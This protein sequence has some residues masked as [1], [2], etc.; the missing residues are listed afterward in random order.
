MMNSHWFLRMTLIGF[1]LG[2][3]F[4]LPG[5]STPRIADPLSNDTWIS[6]GNPEPRILP[7][8]DFSAN[9]VHPRLFFRAEDIPALRE[10]AAREPYETMV[11]LM[12]EYVEQEGEGNPWYELAWRI[13]VMALLHVISGEQ[14]D[15]DRTLDMVQQL[16]RGRSD[17]HRGV[18]HRVEGRQL[19]LSEGSLSVAMAYDFCYHAWPEDAR[20]DISRDLAEQA[21]R[22][23]H[24]YGPG[25]PSRGSANNWRG[26]RFAGAGIALLATDEPHLSP[27]EISA[28]GGNPMNPETPFAGIDPRWFDSAC[29]QVLA[30][31]RHART[32]DPSARGM[33]AE[34]IGYMLYPQTH[35]GPY[36][37]ALEHMLDVRMADDLPAA[38]LGPVLTAMSAV[39]IPAF[40]AN[41]NPVSAGMRPDLA[42]E[43][44]AYANQGELSVSLGL[45][46]EEHRGAYRWHF[47]RF[48]GAGGTADFQP[49]RAGLVFSFL[50][51]PEA[52][53]A[54]NPEEVWGLNLLDAPTGTVI[55][56]DRYADETD[57]VF[58]TTARERGVSRQIHHGPEIGSL[59]LFGEGAF[60]LTGGGR[61]TRLGG[62]SILLN[63][64]R[65]DAGDNRDPGRLAYI[66][67]NENGSGSL[68]LHGSAAGVEEAVRMILLDTETGD[69]A[70]RAYL[71]VADQSRDGNLWRINTP[72][73][74]TVALG[75]N[76]FQI[77]APNGAKLRGDVIFP[78]NV[79]MEQGTWDRSGFVEMH[80]QRSGENHWIQ[81]RIPEGTPTNIVVAMQILP[82]GAEPAPAALRAGGEVTVGTRQ[83]R[84][85]ARSG[86]REASWPE[87]FTLRAE[88]VPA[89]GG[90]V[91][92]T[93][94]YAPG[95]RVELTAVP[96]PGF[97]FV[98]WESPRPM[99]GQPWKT[100]PVYTF[101]I[102]NHTQT[103]AVFEPDRSQ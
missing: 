11:R 43:N 89:H 34:G 24:E 72:G 75:R 33:N 87:R 84:L 59:R 64:D 25:F 58:M 98:R 16:R 54:R 85:D 93:G 23:L 80:D 47:D 2:L 91:R 56:R 8:P 81:A 73:M 79:H 45:V 28:L 95:E 3:S 30:Y 40:D 39:P 38:A 62:Q 90:Q 92:G 68:A 65:L 74:N 46:P 61:T 5:E 77:T 76:A 83:Y 49:N 17:E 37:L 13:R 27:R 94:T 4:N 69:H 66:H 14:A 10:R 42:N 88:A 9:P 48:V 15:A 96:A 36:M 60:F 52:V 20:R 55:L 29:D 67:L 78:A 22:Q 18:W 32:D 21:R 12:R 50:Y 86:L 53:P 41:G 31:L 26:I 82:P 103:R 19:N 44:P 70:A 99:T 6:S 101:K 63:E 57:V 35:L 51:Y 1:C 102:A 71:I 97:R 100:N 7:V